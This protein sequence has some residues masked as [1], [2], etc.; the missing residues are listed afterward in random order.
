MNLI[1]FGDIFSFPEGKAATNRVYTYAKGFIE[2]GMQVYVICFLNDIDQEKEG[3]ADGIHYYQAY[4]PRRRSSSFIR[5]RIDNTRKYFRVIK[6]I[7]DIR[8]KDPDIIINVWTNL[9]KTHLWAWLLSKFFHSELIIECSEHPLRHF[10]K[11]RITRLQGLVKFHVE[12]YLSDGILC[13]SRFLMDFHRNHGVNESKLLLVPS[14]VDPSRFMKKGSRPVPGFYIG[15]FGGLTFYRDSVDTLLKAFSRIFSLYKNINLIIG[16][17][18]T[19]EERLQIHNLIG[20]LKISSRTELLDFRPREEILNYIVYAD[21]LVMVR[22]NDFEATASFPSKLTE[23]LVTGNPVIS[24]TVGE[25]EDF[26]RDGVNAFLVPP[27]NEKLLADKIQYVIDNYQF[28]KQVA[29][30]GREL[31]DG[32]FNY[33]F[34]ASQIINFIN[35]LRSA[36]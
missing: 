19:E 29:E 24:V 21:I 14:T 2:N 13:I 22:S 5:R 30:R 25:I 32:I 7:S 36:K 20:E 33:K 28:A 9:F 17:F 4:S 11:N 15:Y 34:Q 23:Y 8:K 12:S 26:L 16:G 10:L 18:C 31:T 35:S 27:E 3:I 6:I 1:I